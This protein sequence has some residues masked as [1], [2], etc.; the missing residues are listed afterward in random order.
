MSERQKEKGDGR[1]WEMME[2]SLRFEGLNGKKKTGVDNDEQVESE[3][4]EE[5]KIKCF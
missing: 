5:K 4:E 1:V 3:K 2:N